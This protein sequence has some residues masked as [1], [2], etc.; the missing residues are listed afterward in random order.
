MVFYVLA[1]S[2][3]KVFPCEYKVRDNKNQK[4]IKK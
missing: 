4:Q 2:D 1:L 3:S